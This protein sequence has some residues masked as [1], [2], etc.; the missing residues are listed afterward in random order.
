[1]QVNICYICS[2]MNAITIFSLSLSK[3]KN[4]NLKA[5][6]I[7]SAFKI[8]HVLK[9]RKVAFGNKEHTKE[10]KSEIKSLHMKPCSL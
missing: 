2:K 7:I 4:I 6:L 5:G 10:R 3:F 1:M 9:V 8:T